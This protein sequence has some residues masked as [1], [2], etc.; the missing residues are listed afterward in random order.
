MPVSTASN[1]LVRNR[2]VP[3]TAAGHAIAA[4]WAFVSSLPVSGAPSGANST[5]IVS[6]KSRL[7][8]ATEIISPA[9]AGNGTS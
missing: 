9:V 3:E 2:Y 5:A 6:T 8:V 7:L 4:N 1:E